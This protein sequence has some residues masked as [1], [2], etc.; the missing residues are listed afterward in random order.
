M[1]KVL[2]TL[3]AVLMA[4]PAFAINVYNQDDTKVDIY[5]SIRGFLGYG[6]GMSNQDIA[7]VTVDNTSDKFLYGLQ[8]NSRLGFKFAA[9]GFSGQVEFG[10]NEKTL[11]NSAD[12][13]PGIRHIWG[14]YSFGEAGQILIGKTDTPTAMSGFSSDIFF[15]DG[16]LDGFGGNTT[17]SRR[18]QVQYNIAGLSLALIEDDTDSS[19][20]LGSQN[21]SY[22]PR[23]ALAYTFKSPSLL[24]KIGGSYTA[25]NG[26][27]TL[28]NKNKPEWKT[29]HAF[30]VVGGVKAGLLDNNLWIALQLGYDMNGDLFGERK[31]VYTDGSNSAKPLVGFLGSVPSSAVINTQN[32]DIYNVSRVNVAAEIGYKV[33]ENMSLILGGGY[34]YTLYDQLNTTISGVNMS[35]D[36][37]SYG[38]YFQAP[39]TVNKYLMFIPQVGYYATAGYATVSQV[40]SNATKSSVLLGMQMRVN[41]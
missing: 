22:I 24:A 11:R 41:F 21:I 28:E 7:G 25:V 23:I 32:G 15:T 3:L 8:G 38:V 26:D 17:G 30:N 6:H 35:T 14:A 13:T 34:Q 40:D 9:S 20:G 29:I 36:I 1:K 5:G 16:G 37:H 18:F 12:K 31:T 10:L 2:F 33:I 4:V 39:Y 27:I 19:A